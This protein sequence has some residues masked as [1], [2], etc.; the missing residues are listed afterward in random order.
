MGGPEK[1]VVSIVHRCGHIPLRFRCTE[2]FIDGD[3]TAAFKFRS[4]AN[5]PD[6]VQ[7]PRVAVLVTVDRV[8]Y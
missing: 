4:W 2:V 6:R 7:I 3:I 1:G 5:G 8:R